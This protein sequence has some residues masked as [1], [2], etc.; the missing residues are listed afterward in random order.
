MKADYTLYS[1]AQLAD[2]LNQRDKEAFEE[3]YNRYWGLLFSH[4]NKMLRDEDQA[5]DVVQ[6]LFANLLSQMGEFYYK[7]TISSF[8]YTSVRNMVLNLIRYNKVRVNY[9]DSLQDY[10]NKGEWATDEVLRENELSRQI[11]KEIQNLPP[12]MRAIFELSRK[13]YLSH[14]EIAEATGVSEG[15]VKKQLYYAI[16]KLRSKLSSLFWLQLMSAILWLNRTF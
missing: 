16:A 14:R 10:Y 7:S 4:A 1:D 5:Q 13:Q 9:A 15:T 8:L 2:L 11:E 6:E 3:I 12:K